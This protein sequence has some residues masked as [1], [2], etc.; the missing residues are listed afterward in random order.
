MVWNSRQLSHTFVDR[1]PIPLVEGICRE[2][3][4]IEEWLDVTLPKTLIRYEGEGR[5]LTETR[6]ATG[7]PVGAVYRRLT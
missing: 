4:Y 3:V 7:D 2:T 1:K 5:Q 6:K